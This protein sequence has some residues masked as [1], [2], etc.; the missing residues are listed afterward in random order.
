MPEVAHR[1]TF[2]SAQ[3]PHRYAQARPRTSRE[4]GLLHLPVRL[5]PL[6]QLQPHQLPFPAR[7]LMP[8]P[9]CCAMAKTCKASPSQT[10]NQT[11]IHR[12]YIGRSPASQRAE[13]SFDRGV[14]S[15]HGF[16]RADKPS[17]F[18]ARADFKS[19]RGVRSR[20]F[21]ASCPAVHLL[22]DSEPG[23]SRLRKQGCT[24][25]NSETTSK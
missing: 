23:F 25:P 15:A 24:L 7:K 5:G 21:S 4:R 12:G 19:A 11:S 17:T 1:P 16:S 22:L 20:F 9:P 8:H 14:V 6:R 2:N 10:R 18:D 13:K 3:P